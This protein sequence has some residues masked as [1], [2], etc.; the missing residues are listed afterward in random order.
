MLNLVASWQRTLPP[1][2]GATVRKALHPEILGCWEIFFLPE[3]FLR[4]KAPARREFSASNCENLAG[5]SRAF[6]SAFW[7]ALSLCRH[8][9]KFQIIF[10]YILYENSKWKLSMFFNNNWVLEIWN[11]LP[12]NCNFLLHPNFVNPQYRWSYFHSTFFAWSE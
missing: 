11:S 9:S 1:P 3:K 8:M 4:K 7:S 10:L 6:L 12:V 5:L 2:P